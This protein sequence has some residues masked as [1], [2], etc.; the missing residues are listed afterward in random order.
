MRNVCSHKHYQRRQVGFIFREATFFVHHLLVQSKMQ[1]TLC[2]WWR[3][4]YYLSITCI[5]CQISYEECSD[6]QTFMSLLI[7]WQLQQWITKQT[8]AQ[9]GIT[10]IFFRKVKMLYLFVPEWC[11]VCVYCITTSL[12]QGFICF[13]SVGCWDMKKV[14]TPLLSKMGNF[15]ISACIICLITISRDFYS[16]VVLPG[17]CT[18]QN[19]IFLKF[20]LNLISFADFQFK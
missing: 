2:K 7:I 16:R 18:I 19:W 10:H 9:A 6:C 1:N 5:K 8:L 14:L 4:A 20:L 11:N 17:L 13:D 12:H 3:F 15:Q